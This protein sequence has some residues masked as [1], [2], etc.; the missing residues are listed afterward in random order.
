MRRP[1]LRGTILSRLWPVMAGTALVL[2]AAACT[3]QGLRHHQDDGARRLYIAGALDQVSDRA[4]V[5]AARP[6]LQDAFFELDLDAIREA[7][8]A[9]PWLASV[10][11]HRRWPD[12]VVVRVRE[13]R[14]VAL[15]GEDA[16]LA[17]DGTLFTPRGGERPAG[18]PVLS[19]PAGSQARLQ[20]RLA[21]LQ[22]A[23]APAGRTIVRLSM[24]PRGAWQAVLDDG[25]TLRLGRTDIETRASRFAR[26]AAPSLGERLQDAGYVDLRYGD[27]FAVGGKRN[28][29][30]EET[31]NEQAA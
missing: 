31:E 14:P 15:W 20:A 29:T 4:I 5:A 10:S 28:V 22:E 26:Y 25:L 21:G 3:W 19:G 9:E 27:G 6:H 1:N 16:V 8:A 13:H 30:V 17:S 24:D 2:G 18:L 11:V 12:G 7:I 23:V